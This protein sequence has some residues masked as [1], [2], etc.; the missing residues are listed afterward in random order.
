ME[1]KPEKTKTNPQTETKTHNFTSKTSNIVTNDDKN[2]S[3]LIETIKKNQSFGNLLNYSLHSII[4]LISNQS[5]NEYINNSLLLI[6]KGLLTDFPKIISLNLNDEEI[7]FKSCGVVLKIIIN[8]NKDGIDGNNSLNELKNSFFKSNGID[9]ITSIINSLIDDKVI[10]FYLNSLNYLLKSIE[11]LVL[12]IE[13]S[14]N[15]SLIWEI[16]LRLLCI[17][18]TYRD[19]LKDINIDEIVNKIILKRNERLNQSSLSLN[20]NKKVSIFNRQST[21]NIEYDCENIINTTYDDVIYRLLSITKTLIQREEGLLNESLYNI[22]KQYMINEEMEKIILLLNEIFNFYSNYSSQLKK[23]VIIISLSKKFSNP[24]HFFMLLMNYLDQDT[25]EYLKNLLKGEYNINNLILDLFKSDSKKKIYLVKSNICLLL[26]FLSK[27]NNKTDVLGDDSLTS[28]IDSI[29]N[30]M[31]IDHHS[32]IL[33][34][35]I[36]LLITQV[37]P[38]LDDD[39]LTYIEMINISNCFDCLIS[40]NHIILLSFIKLINICF[41]YIDNEKKGVVEVVSKLFVYNFYTNQEYRNA[42]ILNLRNLREEI[43]SVSSLS[44]PGTRLVEGQGNVIDNNNLLRSYRSKSNSYMSH[45]SLF[46]FMINFLIQINKKIDFYIN[47]DRISISNTELSLTKAYSNITNIDISKENSINISFINVNKAVDKVILDIKRLNSQLEVNNPHEKKEFDEILLKIYSLIYNI[48]SNDHYNLNTFHEYIV[49][50]NKLLKTSIDSMYIEAFLLVYFTFYNK[51][52]GNINSKHQLLQYFLETILEKTPISLY[53]ILYLLANKADCFEFDFISNEI[54]SYIYSLNKKT[55]INICKALSHDFL[56]LD[57]QKN[58]FLIKNIFELF[59]KCFDSK[60][61]KDDENMVF[62]YENA[63]FE[64]I[65]SL[66][67]VKDKDLVS[68]CVLFIKFMEEETQMLRFLEDEENFDMYC[69]VI[70]MFS[71]S[72]S[73]VSV[74]KTLLSYIVS[75]F[76]KEIF[77]KSPFES[78]EFLY[79]LLDELEQ[80][81]SQVNPN[82]YGIYN[83]LLDDFIGILQ[84]IINIFNNNSM[85]V[86]II[87]SSK[88]FSSYIDLNTYNLTEFIGNYGYDSIIKTKIVSGYKANINQ[89]YINKSFES[90]V[91]SYITLM[92]TYQKGVFVLIQFSEMD[93][94]KDDREYDKISIISNLSVV[95]ERL[96]VSVISLLCISKNKSVYNGMSVVDVGSMN[97]DIDIG[98]GINIGI[99]IDKEKEKEKDKNDSLNQDI[100][101]ANKEN[102]EEIKAEVNEDNENE[103]EDNEKFLQFRNRKY[104]KSSKKHFIRILSSMITS[105]NKSIRVYILINKNHDNIITKQW[106]STLES[107]IKNS[108]LFKDLHEEYSLLK[109]ILAE[110]LCGYNDEIT[111]T[112]SQKDIKK[113]SLSIQEKDINVK[114][115]IESLNI[116][117]KD[118]ENSNEKYE[119]SLKEYIKLVSYLNCN[120]AVEAKAISSNLILKNLY[121]I[122]DETFQQLYLTPNTSNSNGNISTSQVNDSSRQEFKKVITRKS[123]LLGSSSKALIVSKTIIMNNYSISKESSSNSN[124]K[125]VQKRESMMSLN[126]KALK[127]I[128]FSEDKS[129]ILNMTISI[130]STLKL[131]SHICG[132]DIN[133]IKF[134]FDLLVFIYETIN[135]VSLMSVIDSETFTMFKKESL[136]EIISIFVNIIIT[137][138][139]KAKKIIEFIEFNR[140]FDF[141]DMYLSEPYNIKHIMMLVLHMVTRSK[142]IRFFEERLVGQMIK[143]LN[144]YITDIQIMSIYFHI[145]KELQTEKEIINELVKQRIALKLNT[146]LMKSSASNNFIE[147][148]YSLYCEMLMSKSFGKEIVEEPL[149]LVN[150]IKNYDIKD[151]ESNIK[152]LNI[153]LIGLKNYDKLSLIYLLDHFSSLIINLITIN[154]T[155]TVSLEPLKHSLEV[156]LLIS[157]Y[158]SKNSNDNLTNNQP[159]ESMKSSSK[160]EISKF[161]FVDETIHYLRTGFGIN[162]ENGNLTQNQN[163]FSYSNLSI[164]NLINK[165]TFILLVGLYK[166][167]INSIDIVILLLKIFDQLCLFKSFD[168]FIDMNLLI[169]ALNITYITYYENFL[170]INQV[171]ILF[172]NI[173]IYH[174]TNSQ[175]EYLI[176]LILYI[177]ENKIKRKDIIIFL[178]ETLGYLIKFYNEFSIEFIQLGIKLFGSTDDIIISF[179]D[180]LYKIIKNKLTFTDKTIFDYVISFYEKIEKSEKKDLVGNFVKVISVVSKFYGKEIISNYFLF[181]INKASDFFPFNFVIIQGIESISKHFYNDKSLDNDEICKKLIELFYSF[182]SSGNEVKLKERIKEFECVSQVIFNISIKSSIVKNI[183]IDNKFNLNVKQL[184]EQGVFNNYSSL[185]YIIKGIIINLKEQKKENFNQQQKG[186]NN[187]LKNMKL[188]L[189]VTEIKPDQKDFLVTPHKARM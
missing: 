64:Y 37:E 147:Y 140:V 108:I 143:I 182:L 40:K 168:T 165:E 35:L 148:I 104:T 9:I 92:E 115:T 123:S 153:L 28:I 173:F 99:N 76:K 105:L 187:A 150:L 69:K 21:N 78:N 158:F 152:V 3:T 46:S 128:Y 52:F 98:I 96:K 6:D 113:V 129:Q 79:H 189:K 89:I 106:M 110:V 114:H 77:I 80:V 109:L 121:I 127:R 19:V 4:L 126:K 141:I 68:N 73:D 58:P 142:S 186:S 162:K 83:R 15:I 130:V 18:S 1:I 103:D 7:V 166:H 157:I 11:I 112:F 43:Y 30:E 107:S 12:Y 13:N 172:Q 59:Y 66:V 154:S 177:I 62:F 135:T 94:Y 17:F 74:Y 90:I 25:I 86:S 120:F 101:Q 38:R 33:Q 47:L 102:K 139:V 181:I 176:K 93:F 164:S 23:D 2:I 122:L 136:I 133:K 167:Y 85:E 151:N 81:N 29:N 175:K 95:I 36:D 41:S 67:Y 161:S 63:F 54:Q 55:L 170:I 71:I 34:Y 14:S 131:F 75:T 22:L 155:N 84:Y 57:D 138:E 169:E 124:L 132:F 188:C 178:F 20:S 100:Q 65:T 61:S 97:R 32:K 119:I 60:H 44:T 134:S 72:F 156:F 53:Y 24:K 118:A 5:S 144:L 174:T 50:I 10:Y 179:S 185:V 146:I 184:L 49:L 125:P 116:K 91:D 42:F 159:L 183:L 163:V 137:D 51:K 160:S 87:L 45:I 26:T 39:S 16:I 48:I 70:S 111:S 56:I 31:S 82:E 117:L 171:S 8:F 88:G 180:L 145:L 27:R 149:L